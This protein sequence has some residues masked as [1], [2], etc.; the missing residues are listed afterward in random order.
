MQESGFQPA[1]CVGARFPAR[2]KTLKFRYICC[3]NPVCFILEHLLMLERYPRIFSLSLTL[4]FFA[5]IW[6]Y[7]KEFRYF[8]NAIEARQLVIGAMVFGL[9]LALGLLWLFAARF[10]PAGNHLPEIF[11]IVITC[12]LMMPLPASLINRSLGTQGF[13]SFEFVSETPF[14]ASG[15]GLLKG[16]KPLPNGYLLTVQEQGR[17]VKFKYKR[18]AY[19]PLTPKGEV[20]MLPMLNGFLGVRVMMLD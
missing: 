15:Y 10:K 19:Y 2:R 20:V 3:G 5:L 13:V 11:F 7:V 12:T 14:Y 16:E 6:L 4:V 17:F 8:S 18:Q 1:G 9:L